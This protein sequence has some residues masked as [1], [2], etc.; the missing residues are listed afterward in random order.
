MATYTRVIE[1]LTL[2]ST[3]DIIGPEWDNTLIRN[4]TIKDVRGDGMMIR[5]VDNL[6]IENVTFENVS[7]YGIRLSSTGSTS[8]VVIADSTFTNI[9]R[10]GIIAAQDKAKGVD[11]PGLQI[12]N[13]TIDSTGLNGG[14]T[15]MMHGMY[16]QATDFLI[17]GNHIINSTDANGISVRSS[18]VISNNLIENARGSGVAYFADHHK[19]PSDLLVIENNTIINT[20]IGTNR[21]DVN[22]LGIPSGQTNAAVSNFIV[23]D[24]N[25][26]D[27]DR[28]PVA[29]SSD[30]GRLGGDIVIENNTQ[31][32]TVADYNP[33]NPV[34][35]QPVV[36]QPVV[37]QPVVKEPVVEEPVV[38][39]PVVEQ[40]I[41]VQEQA[42]E[43]PAV[44]QPTTQP[45]PTDSSADSVTFNVSLSGANGSRTIVK[46]SADDFDFA[47]IRVGSKT[48]FEKTSLAETGM[49]FSATN[50]S[51]SA[52]VSVHD[53]R[54]GVVSSGES[55]NQATQLSSGETL[56]IRFDDHDLVDDAFVFRAQLGSVRNG[57]GVNVTAYRDGAKVSEA[58]IQ[59]NGSQLTF[60]PGMAFDHIE[61]TPDEGD[62]FFISAFEADRVLY[63]E[64]L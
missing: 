47:Q 10:D 38:E 26:S 44:Q 6:R 19:G 33:G 36:Q 49:S 11:H 21:S 51:G 56:S 8:D 64:F 12:L 16:I 39:E 27:N 22:L 63:D 40:P 59:L 53:G 43:K 5:N 1:N 4:V 42:A 60:A 58:D 23:R 30:Y 2:T 52:N 15:N 50:A 29:V 48:Q 45:E 41:V 3:M 35:Q 31:G 7:G 61:L 9:G 24:N 32:A 62:S 28:T 54:L 13:N 20:G 46:Q 34:V 25:F 37:E 57:E 18:G 14:T 55:L 17:D